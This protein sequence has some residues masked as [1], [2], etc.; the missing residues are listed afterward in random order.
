MEEDDPNLNPKEV[1][2]Q[3]E[4]DKLIKLARGECP[5]PRH[6][7]SYIKWEVWARVSARLTPTDKAIKVTPS[8]LREGLGKIDCNAMS[9][10]GR[11][12]IDWGP[13]PVDTILEFLLKKK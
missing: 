3:K 11:C 8:K 5:C 10:E 12:L 9:Q 6:K 13:C 1:N 4:A 7:E 2:H